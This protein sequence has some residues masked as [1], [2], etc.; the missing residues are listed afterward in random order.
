[1]IQNLSLITD[2]SCGSNVHTAFFVRLENFRSIRSLSWKGLKRVYHFDAIR[3]GIQAHGQQIESLTLDLIDWD[4]VQLSYL[5]GRTNISPLLVE[6]DE[7]S[8]LASDVF[9]LSTG[10]DENLLPI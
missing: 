1:M 6:P 9:D 3:D 4:D 8:F 2:N 7:P 10:D 5:K